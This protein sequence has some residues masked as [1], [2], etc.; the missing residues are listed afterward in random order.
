[1]NINDVFE[2]L[3]QIG[4]AA[5]IDSN[6]NI[7]FYD[8][9]NE[10]IMEA[11]C[12]KNPLPLVPTDEI[13]SL[14][15]IS[16]IDTDKFI[17]LRSPKKMFR[18]VL[19]RPLVDKSVDRQSLIIENAQYVVV[20][21]E[22]TFDEHDISFSSSPRSKI[23]KINSHRGDG[24]HSEITIQ[25]DE[26]MTF[27]NSDGYGEFY[28]GFDSESEL[29]SSQMIQMYDSIELIPVLARYYG[30]LYS[31]LT[32]TIDSFVEEKKSRLHM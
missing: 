11:M 16:E 12:T 28:K 3:K 8:L 29:Q 23:L 25:N 24:T 17:T 10:C 32:K 27:S 20:T 18:F 7:T 22:K 30:K 15:S 4:I 5:K 26:C 9:E 19:G 2:L 31:E 1:M 13:D 14:T 21:G 6:G